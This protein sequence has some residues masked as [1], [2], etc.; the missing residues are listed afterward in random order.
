[1]CQPFFFPVSSLTSLSLSHSCRWN[2]PTA[3]STPWHCL[4]PPPPSL[5]L[6]LS[7][8][9]TSLPSH[10][11]TTGRP[12]PTTNPFFASLPPVHPRTRRQSPTI[13]IVTVNSG[14]RMRLYQQHHH[15][16]PALPPLLPQP[17]LPIQP[18]ATKT[19]TTTTH[20]TLTTPTH[21]PVHTLIHWALPPP[22]PTH[23][24]TL[25]HTLERGP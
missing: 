4:S 6:P 17:L 19:T 2:K 8:T 15:H 20:Y 1:M 9:T 13:V 16:T 24:L 25:T 7:R 21:T 14:F 22:H 23:P 5:P 11:T 3:M 18:E 12:S 10:T